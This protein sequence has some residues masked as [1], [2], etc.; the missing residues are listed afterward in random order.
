VADCV[1]LLLQ[2]HPTW[3]PGDI[4]AALIN[5]ASQPNRPD[6][7]IGYGVVYV[8]AAL[9]FNPCD[10]SHTGEKLPGVKAGQTIAA[11]PNPFYLDQYSA[12]EIA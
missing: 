12:A 8:L 4:R 7:Y 10:S 6:N 5:S 1:D 9:N 3:S 11:Y 2:A